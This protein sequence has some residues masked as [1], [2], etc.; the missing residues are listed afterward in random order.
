MTHPADPGSPTAVAALTGTS[1]SAESQFDAIVASPLRAVLLTILHRRSDESFDIEALMGLAGCM[2]VDAERC[3]EALISSGLAKRWPAG[4]G[5]YVA[6]RPPS[7]ELERLLAAF[8]RARRQDGQAGEPPSVRRLRE[9]VGRDEKMLAV[10][11]SVRTAAKTD[12]SVLILGPTGV[13][14]EVAARAIHELG[15][16]RSHAFQAVNCAAVP[17]TLFESE[18][19]GHERGAFTGAVDRRVGKIELANRGT[20]FLD[21]MG[22]LPLMSQAKMLRVLEERRLDR[23][24][25]QH[26][27]E[28]DFRLISATNRPLELLVSERRFREDLYYRLNAF[29]IRLP[30]LKERRDDVPVLAQLFLARHL[31]AEGV[32]P[33]RRRFSPAAL[34]RLAL[35]PWPGNVR[36]LISTITRAALSSEGTVI[37]ARDLSFL[38]C[39]GLTPGGGPAVRP[40]ADVEREHIESALEAT[41]WNKKET[42]RLLGISRE[43]LYRKI[44]TY[45][46]VSNKISA[47]TLEAEETN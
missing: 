11:E 13:G 32:P 38:S 26:A 39:E 1:P 44:R 15:R 46:L 17:D 27:I 9:L 41:N 21:E 30:A 8:V 36:E 25:G 5:R 29:T 16:R 47:R 2:R 3:L 19:F 45:G 10:L 42:A 37:E 12:I 40:L 18:L 34:E 4:S 6:V 24:G 31:E 43:T 33:D 23:L 28:V 14:K 35:Y 22:D 20:L 7:P